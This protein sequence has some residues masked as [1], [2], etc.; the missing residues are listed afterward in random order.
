MDPKIE[1]VAHAA[2]VAALAHTEK[3]CHI[4]LHE[5]CQFR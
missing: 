4:E 1:Q 2:Y 3:E 5:S